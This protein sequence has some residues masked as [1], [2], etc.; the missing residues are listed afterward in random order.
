MWATEPSVETTALPESIWR[1][2]SDVATWADWNDDI[3]RVDISEPFAAGGTIAMTPVGQETVMLRITEVSEPRLFVDE[4]DV[5]D[6]VV[7][8]V[9]RIDQLENGRSRII[10]RMEITGPAADQIGPQLGPQ[11]SSDFPQLLSALVERAVGA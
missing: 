6:A 11:I 3:E 4:A 8:T 1:L 10:Y 7:R 2:W 5:D 9:H